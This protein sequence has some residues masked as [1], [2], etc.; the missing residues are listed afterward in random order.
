MN[1]HGY[2]K[3]LAKCQLCPWNCKANRLEGEMGAC[4][5]GLPEVAYTGLNPVLKTFAVTLLACS[6]RCI[7]CNAYRISRTLILAGHIVVMWLL[8]N[9]CWKF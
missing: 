2:L 5:A 3:D 1:G 8:I 4:H 7:Y 6:F 9:W